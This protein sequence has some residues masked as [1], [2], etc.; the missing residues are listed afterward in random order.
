MVIWRDLPKIEKRCRNPQK[1]GA[2][3]L[4]IIIQKVFIRANF[5]LVKIAFESSL[6]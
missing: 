4:H 3:I 6:G 5:C 1:M 2:N